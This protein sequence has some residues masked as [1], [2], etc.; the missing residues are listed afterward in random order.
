MPRLLPISLWACVVI[1]LSQPARTEAEPPDT[2]YIF[3]AG[4]QRGTKVQ[5][6]IGGFYLHERAPL[7]WLGQGISGP[8][9]IE[10]TA[11]RWFEG[12]LIKQPA[13]QRKE[14]YP[15]DYAA[16]L[17]IAPDA[18]LGAHGWR[19]WGGQ[20]ATPIRPFIVG[21]L[22]EVV[23]NETDGDPLPV[24]VT[25]PVT[26]NGR[27]F[28]REDLDQWSFAAEAGESLTVAVVAKQIGSPLEALIEVRSPTGEVL[29]ESTGTLNRD[30]QLRFKV[31]TSG[32]YSVRI[33]DTRAE[34][35]QNYVYRLTIT[36][37]PWIDAIYPL[38]GQRGSSTKF[39][40]LGQGVEAIEETLP[41]SAARVIT[42]HFTRQG[43]PLNAV[44]LELDDLPELREQEPN[45]TPEQ[46]QSVS[47][48]TVANGRIQQ[49]GDKDH[50]SLE[51]KKGDA[52][53]FEVRAARL[54][55]PL[56][57]VLS[58]QDDTSKELARGEDL[59]S[60][61]PDCELKFI[62]PAD[63]SYQV[64]L[65]EKFTSRGGPSFAYRLRCMKA[66]ADFAL[67]INVDS[68]A[69]D[70][71]G[72]KKLPVVITRIGG[73]NG[74]I[75]LAAEGLPSGVT[76]PAVEVKGNQS[77]ADL[78]FTVD[79]TVPVTR[80]PIRILG[81]AEI[82]GA[83]K[84]H[85]ASIVAPQNPNQNQP[86]ALGLVEVDHLLLVTS[87]PT[88]FKFI[89]P[90]DTQFIARG[91]TMRK[92]FE[93]ERGGFEGPLWVELAD[94]QGRHLQGV[95]A[96]RQNIPPGVNEFE[97]EVMLP[98][99]M[100]LGRTS[101]SQL[102]IVGEVPDAAGK[103]HKVVFTANGQNDQLIAIV[104]PGPIRVQPERSSLLI[105]KGA[106]ITIPLQV[107][108]DQTVRQNLKIEL[109]V[110]EHMQGL[111]AQPVEVK[112][113]DKAAQLVLRCGDNP[114]PLNMPVTIRT[115][116]ERNGKPVVAE[117]LLTLLLQP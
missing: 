68:L 5:A 56:D 82:D 24:A 30:P 96:E 34:G 64:I 60:G 97:F 36:T 69:A 107:T 84:E 55:S 92:R 95:V 38:G 86:V 72:T 109:I 111:S 90:F 21:M 31:P 57:A 26:I 4:A 66:A 89:A 114:G 13:S 87:L 49:A 106:E 101:R 104:S 76:A 113:H 61:S 6:R 23:E 94:K 39:S 12:P 58:V 35:L 112:P 59:P 116:S 51:L 54:G 88:P 7:E 2:S 29:A 110:P 44:Q 9:E 46:A 50:W 25:L 115:T 47:L 105:S 20:G 63:G 98:P 81:K 53:Q 75:T 45:D 1:A 28:P 74:V 73:F 48:G 91:S 33:T 117:A 37:G 42:H 52:V 85:V 15:K 79:A 40:L 71:A 65:S 11:V 62:A 22:P 17:T 14:D 93:V 41:T 32:Q 77:K 83:T 78:V 43:E 8:A 100:E 27:I 3:P 80:T 99:W 102:M 10:R 70:I 18:P 103:L 108:C 19:S 67:E 16:E